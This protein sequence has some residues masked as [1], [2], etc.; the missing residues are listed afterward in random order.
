MDLNRQGKSLAL[1]FV[2]SRCDKR[3]MNTIN[4]PDG[5]IPGKYQSAEANI[6]PCQVKEFVL[7]GRR[8]MDLAEKPGQKILHS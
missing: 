3:W 6:N 7:H 2:Q 1:T 4:L 8:R 5:D